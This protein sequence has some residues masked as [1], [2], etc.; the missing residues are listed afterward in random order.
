MDLLADELGI[1][2]VELRLLNALEPGDRCRPGS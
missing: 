2:P 1:D